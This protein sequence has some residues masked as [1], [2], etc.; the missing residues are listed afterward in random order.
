ME[1]RMDGRHLLLR[2]DHGEDVIGS[3][4]GAVSGMGGTFMIAVALGMMHEFEIGYFDRGKYIKKKIEEPVELL[5]MSG[6]VSSTGENRVHIH[7]SLAMKDH[8]SIGGHLISGKVWMSE[9]ILLV[10]LP[11]IESRR[12]IDPEK[13]VGILRLDA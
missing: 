7:A 11:E 5:A 10:H 9:E 6:S 12:E 2:L 13:K 8:G 1:K 3:I 4:E